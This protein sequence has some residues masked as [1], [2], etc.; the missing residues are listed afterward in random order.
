[1]ILSDRR[2]FLRRAS[3]AS[4]GASLSPL[5]QSLGASIRSGDGP[6]IPQ[7]FVFFLHGNGIY[8][9][10]IQPEGILIPAETDRLEEAGIGGRELPPAISPLAPHKD[11]LTIVNGLSSRVTGPPLHYG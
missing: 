6:G 2:T 9:R 7:R 1:M 11:R 3:L 10:H 5:A 4:G 8:P